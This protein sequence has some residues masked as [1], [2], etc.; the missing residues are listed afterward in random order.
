[1]NKFYG[2]AIFCAN[3]RMIITEDK[4][5]YECKQVRDL[6][7]EQAHRINLNRHWARARAKWAPHAA[8]FT[9]ISAV[10]PSECSK[11]ATA[12]PF[13]PCAS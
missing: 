12:T 3:C 7:D 4:I 1:M 6:E 9:I 8:A 5:L 10:R 13:A 2:N 11:S